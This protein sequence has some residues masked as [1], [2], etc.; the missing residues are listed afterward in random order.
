LLEQKGVGV[1]IIPMK[2]STVLE[3][4]FATSLLADWTSYYLALAYNQDPTPVDMV[5]EFKE[6]MKK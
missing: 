2:G 5:E 1:E 6:S 3:K 4:I